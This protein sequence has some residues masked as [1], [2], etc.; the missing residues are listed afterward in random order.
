MGSP[1]PDLSAGP[2]R[3]GANGPGGAGKSLFISSTRR[4]GRPCGGATRRRYGRPAAGR[5][6]QL[7]SHV[8][9]VPWSTGVFAVLGHPSPRRG[10]RRSFKPRPQWVGTP[11][12]VCLL[13]C[14]WRTVVTRMAETA[15]G[16]GLHRLVGTGD[17][18]APP[19]LP[20]G[21]RPGR[22]QG[23]PAGCPAADS[24]HQPGLTC[25]VVVYLAERYRYTAVAGP[26]AWASRPGL[27][28]WWA[29]L[30][31]PVTV[32]SGTR[33]RIIR[34]DRRTVMG[35]APAGACTVLIRTKTSGSR[36]SPG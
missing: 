29:L 32:L 13:L 20:A 36:V 15:R 23:M 2:R 10:C 28:G 1:H 17:Y 34:C 12:Q 5:F 21:I 9:A 27:P 26:V 16:S 3:A 7:P 14:W 22:S 11:G 33:P 31:C 4:P 24:T 25:G 35:A 30:A 19:T 8:L 6:S 18:P